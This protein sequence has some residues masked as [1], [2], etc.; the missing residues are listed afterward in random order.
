MGKYCTN[1]GKELH[2][3]ARFCAKCGVAVLDAPA[4]PVP[5]AQ[6]KPVPQTQTKTE[7]QPQEYT[8]PVATPKRKSAAAPK[9]NSG[10]NTL[11]IV[12]SVLL[13]IQIVAVALYGWPGFVVGGGVK[14]PSVQKSDSFTLQE[15]QTAVSTDSGVTVDFGPYNA[16]DGEKV[17]IKELSA[18]SDSIEGGTRT[19]YDISAGERT[20]FDGLLTITLPYDESETDSTD[21]EGSVLAE[22]Y[23]P[24]TGEWELVDYTV[25]AA[26]NTVTITTDHLSEYCTVTLRDAGSPYALL[27][28]FSS[29][30]LDDETAI[31]ILREYE[32]TGQPGEVGDSLLRT[33][34]K[35]FLPMQYQQNLGDAEAEAVHEV[36]GWLTDVS[37]LAAQGGGYK[38]AASVLEKT[39]YMLLGLSTLSLGDTMIDAYKGNESAETVAAEAYKLSYNVGV[40]MLDY[41]KITTGIVQLSMLGVIALDYSLNKFMVAAN[42]T[43]KDALFNVVIAYNEEIHPWTEAEWYARIMGLY[44]NRGDDPEKFNAA[45][46]GIMEN[47]S[48]RYFYDNPEEQLVATNEAG[49]HA[50]TTGLLPETDAAKEYC[51]EQYMAR[52]G[53]RLQPVLSDVAQ[54]M[55]YDSLKAYSKNATELRQALNAPLEFE[56]IEEIPDGEKSKYAGATVVISRPGVPVSGAWTVGLDKDGRA[57]LDATIVGYIQAGLPTQLRLWNKGYDPQEDEPTLTQE[58]KVTEKRT[59]IPLGQEENDTEYYLVERYD[60]DPGIHYYDGY[61][62]E[63]MAVNR[64][65]QANRVTDHLVIGL[66]AEVDQDSYREYDYDPSTGLLTISDDL[67]HMELRPNDDWSAIRGSQ[68]SLS[69][70]VQIPGADSVPSGP[71]CVYYRYIAVTPLSPGKW[72]VNETGETIA[73]VYYSFDASDQQTKRLESPSGQSFLAEARS[74]AAEMGMEMYDGQGYD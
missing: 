9:R 45:L 61:G 50:Y 19:A 17:S 65:L 38:Q 64:D 37:E 52:L 40:A 74:F 30:R 5:A 16:M 46:R 1:C 15:G 7:V 57:S 62:Y 8:P 58:F 67:Y 22:Y 72:R 13:I 71:A 54:R 12:L 6:P 49:L 48:S 31:A 70:S 29:K 20:E 28:K 2:T 47:Y 33:F 53:E 27:S 51:I 42:Q 25:N 59:V 68:I 35:Q 24:E 4:N 66:D 69:Q 63:I 36:V 23:N 39:G 73:Y 55:R 43:Y 26:D 3:G 34:Y 41:K 44:K 11:C 56:I 32:Q 21:E 14:R 10:R 60:F 18:D